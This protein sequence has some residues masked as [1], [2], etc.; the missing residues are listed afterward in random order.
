MVA[1]LYTDSNWE[2]PTWYQKEGWAHTKETDDQQNIA[3][4]LGE[5]EDRHTDTN[6][7]FKQ[8]LYQNKAN[9]SKICIYKTKVRIN[10][11]D[12]PN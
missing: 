7:S 10:N 8:N 6:E 11:L 12:V 3:R 1:L 9:N 4:N 5:K 2:V